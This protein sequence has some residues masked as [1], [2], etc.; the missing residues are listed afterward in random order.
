MIFSW[1]STTYFQIWFQRKV[2]KQYILFIENL[3]SNWFKIY[4]ISKLNRWHGQTGIDRLID[5]LVGD[6]CSRPQRAARSSPPSDL[7]EDRAV[8]LL[9]PSPMT[10]SLWALSYPYVSVHGP[11][12]SSIGEQTVTGAV[13]VSFY[14]LWCI[15]QRAHHQHSS[16]YYMGLSSRAGSWLVREPYG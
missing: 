11:R 10:P 7:T 4:K 2:L 9:A 12:R 1:K 15:R 8:S 3:A 16:L 14:L 13:M 5:R 6:P